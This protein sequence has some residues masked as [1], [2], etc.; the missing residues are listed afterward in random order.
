MSLSLSNGDPREQL[1]SC[2]HTTEGTSIGGV[3]FSSFSE[4]IQLLSQGY[5]WSRIQCQE[6]QSNGLRREVS[7][8]WDR[9][10]TPEPRKLMNCTVNSFLICFLLAYFPWGVWIHCRSNF[11]FPY[12]F[13]TLSNIIFLSPPWRGYPMWMPLSTI[14][15]SGVWRLSFG[16]LVS[17]SVIQQLQLFASHLWEMGGDEVHCTSERALGMHLLSSQIPIKIDCQ[18]QLM[19]F[20]GMLGP[21]PPSVNIFISFQKTT[22]FCFF[23]NLPKYCLWK[24]IKCSQT[25]LW[26]CLR[27]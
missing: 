18:Q 21:R 4:M 17:E 16:W 24:N 20:L 22:V 13:S 10:R 6:N 23:F 12:L 3:L 19:A 15:W 14:L 26:S 7:F 27:M 2:S 8:Q 25:R 5:Y 9:V 1:L 11:F